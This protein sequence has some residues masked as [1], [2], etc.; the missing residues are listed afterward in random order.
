VIAVVVIAVLA[1]V[2]RWAHAGDRPRPVDHGLLTEIATAPDL[3]AAQELR[4]LLAD[5]GI[6][7]TLSTDHLGRT[8]VLVFVVDAGRARDLVV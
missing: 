2:L 8:R 7:S 3:A 4:G 5:A 1:L 6:R